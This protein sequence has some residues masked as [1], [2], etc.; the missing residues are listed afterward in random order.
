MPDQRPSLMLQ[1]SAG[2]APRTQGPGAELA[3]LL[4]GTRA[5]EGL[6]E[7][8]RRHSHTKKLRPS[9]SWPLGAVRPRPLGLGMPRGLSEILHV[10]CGAIG[11]R[12]GCSVM[13]AV[14][15]LSYC[16]RS[17]PSER[18][19]VLL[20]F[21]VWGC[22]GLPAAW[23]G[24]SPCLC[25]GDPRAT[26]RVYPQHSEAVTPLSPAG[27]GASMSEPSLG[28]TP[29][30]VHA[31]GVPTHPGMTGPLT[32][33][34]RGPP[35]ASVPGA[36]PPSCTPGLQRRRECHAVPSSR[37]SP[38]SLPQINYQHAQVPAERAHRREQ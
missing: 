20:S 28:S 23:S 29:V 24:L 8:P 32:A 33:E 21:G 13:P 22:S 5:Q 12:G 10:T 16:H 38:L 1:G 36:R 2:T 35:T 3:R 4:Q 30:P 31:P 15:L 26:P 17:R 25:S 9:P 14:P 18:R 27:A 37:A 6:W 11:A 19:G 34:R 7:P